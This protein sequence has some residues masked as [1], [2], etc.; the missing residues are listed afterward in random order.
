MTTETKDKSEY[1]KALDLMTRY[2]ALRDHSRYEL[3]TKLNRRFDSKLVDRLLAE[4]EDRGWLGDEQEM[5]ERLVL[6][7]ERKLKSRRYI[8]DQLRK[9]R[10]PL[11]AANAESEIEKARALAERKF[12]DLSAIAFEERA[13]VFRFLK[14]RGFT[15]HSIRQVLNAKS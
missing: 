2:L 10:L 1:T 7:L 14:Y 12:G 13:K 4:A 8:E 5:A 11:P 6:S 15:D 9:K 3:K